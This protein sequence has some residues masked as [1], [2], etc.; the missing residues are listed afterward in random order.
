MKTATRLWMGAIG[1]IRFAWREFIVTD[2]AY[3]ILALALL[4]PTVGLMQRVALGLSGSE[5]QADQDILYFFLSPLGLLTL[6]LIAGGAV[7]I[8][9]LELACLMVI[10]QAARA[11][12]RVTVRDALGFTLARGLPILRLA[13]HLVVRLLLLAL[14]FVAIAGG[15]AWRLLSEHDINYYLLNRPPEFV[16][17][18]LAIGLVA[19]AMLALLAEKLLSWVY[20]MPLV[21]F[22]DVGPG[23]SFAVSAT[24]TAGHRW[25]L[26]A[27]LVGWLGV[28]LIG[29]AA[30]LG[31][32]RILGIGLSML[33]E[34]RVTM[35]LAAAAGLLVFW[36]AASVVVSLLSNCLFSVLTVNAYR[37]L[38]DGRP[39]YLPGSGDASATPGGALTSRP[40]QVLFAA[41]A[42]AALV[43]GWSLLDGIDT[44]Q[45]V[46]VIA[47]RGAAGSAPENTLAAV[48]QAIVQGADFVE[49]DVQET[50]DG[51]VVV[52][53]DSD[54]MKIAGVPTK[55]W[56][57][58]D[59]ELTDI[60]IGSWFAPEFADQR[61]PTLSQVLALTRDRSRTVIELKY[62]GHER[63][64]AERVVETV[65]AAD[66][67]SNVMLMSLSYDAVRRLNSLR[68]D[69]TVGLLV[70]KALG[71]L[72]RVEAD[73][74]AVNA[75]MA[76]RRFTRDAQAAGKRVFV[77]TLNEPAD[78]SRM[79][80]R[81]VDGIITDHPGLARQILT[82]RAS[83]GS[84]ERLLL[85]AGLM[86]GATP[87][88]VDEARELAGPG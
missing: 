1:D 19:V 13:T 83:L 12:R 52:I 78:I 50:A 66:A 67:T 27:L 3:K 42:V 44:E 21:L 54:L 36:F 71:N 4:L 72:S 59:D 32:V 62:Y 5:F 60:D 85:D 15:I 40:L 2:V 73:F 7:A 25:R 84:V 14:P 20:V 46:V 28:T 6:P 65:E 31:L 47:H 56:E 49:I 79:V 69:W 48:E 68:P 53:H 64:L 22:E 51:T 45:D 58:R 57:L 70:A 35:L 63:R 8:I 41:T 74:L 9:V 24:R 82:H 37:R 30:I 16:L 34:Q 26:A 76:T 10:G 87:E 38:G 88:P 43:S 86:L 17:A 33:F 80:S 77:W 23:A 55:T 39:L 29:S 18:A 75:G 61:V 11:R 81:G